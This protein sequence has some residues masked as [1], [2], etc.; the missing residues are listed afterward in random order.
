MKP[1]AIIN[2]AEYAP[3]LPSCRPVESLVEGRYRVSFASTPEDYLAALRLRFE[4]FNMELGEGLAE[5]YETGFDQDRFD[6]SFHH[7]IIRDTEVDRIVGTYRMQ[8]WEMADTGAGF[9]SDGEFALNQLPPEVLQQG[10][11]IGRA[12][13]DLEY[14]NRQVLFLLWKGLAQYMAFN[15]KRYFFGCCSIT[16]QNLQ[17][18]LAVDRHLQEKQ[19]VHPDLRVEVRDSYKCEPSTEDPP[20][21]DEVKIPPLFKLY[22]RYG[23]RVISPPAVDREF[24]TIDWLV[25]FDFEQLAAHS[26]KLFFG[27]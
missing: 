12:S 4:V 21:Q 8:T 20:F 5:S 1:D 15:K 2:P 17:E 13:V 3:H 9:Y 22:L 23:S 11:E 18:G 24:K 16:S 19:W 25:A 26:R 27:Y 6:P 10:I 7:L 14:R